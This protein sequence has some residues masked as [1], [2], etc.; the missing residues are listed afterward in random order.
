MNDYDFSSLN[1]KEF[2]Q[3]V[4]DLLNRKH[5]WN[6]QSFAAGRDKGIDM[7]YASPGNSNELI[8]QAKHLLHSS[9]SKLKSALLNKELPK[10]HQLR[11]W[12][13]ILVTSQ[14]MTVMR[15]EE[16]Q[17][18]FA[19]FVLT[20]DDI[21]GREELNKYLVEF[22]DLEIKYFKLWFSSVP[23]LNTILNNAIEGRTAALL[24]ELTAKGRLYVV[25]EKLDDA[26]KVLLE[27]KILIVTGEPG[28]GKTT[29]AGMLL[30]ER[31][32]FGCKVYKVETIR[33][34]EDVFSF[35][36]E[37]RQ[38]FYFDDFLGSNHAEIINANRTETQLTSFVER[39]RATPNKYLILTSRTVILNHAVESYQKI[40]R[41]GLSDRKFEIRLTDYTKF[42]K[43]LILYNHLYFRE[44]K[45]EF[46]NVIITDGLYKSIVGHPN[47]SPRIMEFITDKPKI[48]NFS[49][50]EYRQFIVNNLDNPREIWRY[51]FNNQIGHMERCLLVTLFTFEQNVHEIKLAKAFESRQLHE[52]TVYNQVT[53]A[54]QFEQSIKIL[55]DGFVAVTMSDTTTQTRTYSLLNPS[56]GDFIIG[57]LKESYLEKKAVLQSC[58]YYEQ[59]DR[60]YP[61]K[62][63]F[64]LEPELQEIIRDKLSPQ[65]LVVQRNFVFRTYMNLLTKTLVDL[66]VFCSDV[67]A[68]AACVQLLKKV[69]FSE[70]ETMDAD[71]MVR[72]MT[73]IP[74]WPASLQF[75]R[76]NFATIVLAVLGLIDD[77][78]TALALPPLFKKYRIDFEKFAGSE[79]GYKLLRD[80][81]NTILADREE[82]ISHDY[83]KSTD[84]DE[85]NDAYSELQ[86]DDRELIAALFPGQ[87]WV[88]TSCPEMDYFHW[89]ELIDKNAS[90]EEPQHDDSDDR[91]YYDRTDTTAESTN[92]DAA[93][94]D[95]FS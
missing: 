26:K 65:P 54:G 50:D 62:K 60:F 41:S 28:I 66:T 51:S 69:K 88:D 33:E 14:P 56:L 73:D 85:V 91:Y 8:V 59:L 35:N 82:R 45:E 81:V 58:Y 53:H 32:K 84:I 47:Y 4:R 22:S 79:R 64:R 75:L 37:E 83:K 67:D 20:V 92:P 40:A 86:T 90:T 43:A 25:T 2:E 13:Y 55:L 48:T 39:V 3:L 57:L 16:L 27:E 31:A 23:V 6:L 78:D 38:V 34:A 1:D 36:D 18:M 17:Q 24:K 15:Q 80:M 68:D 46:Y 9:Y 63:V 61:R 11:P 19:P 12:R 29:I 30:M 70:L 52:K 89:K 42:E 74:V 76:E 71:R 49:P 95:L 5:G 72:F 21:I 44:V 93:I 77:K 10:V 94:D 7:R 87:D